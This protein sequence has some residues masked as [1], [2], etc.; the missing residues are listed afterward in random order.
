MAEATHPPPPPAPRDTLAE[1][2]FKLMLRRVSRSK[3]NQG[4][5]RGKEKIF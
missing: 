3:G 4:T 5:T 1:V 2:T